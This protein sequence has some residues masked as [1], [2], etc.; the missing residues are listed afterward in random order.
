MEYII[1]IITIIPA[2]YFLG[3][4]FKKEG[5]LKIYENP[6]ILIYFIIAFGYFYIYWFV[7]E[8]L[9][10]YVKINNGIQMIFYGIFCLAPL[11]KTDLPN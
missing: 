4:L 6:L 7:P 1:I 2:V 10:D 5:R 11:F 9:Y 3:F 8:I